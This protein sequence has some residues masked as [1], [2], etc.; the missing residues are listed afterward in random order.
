MKKFLLFVA[1]GIV[2]SSTAA[3]QQSVNWTEQDRNYL[4]TELTRSRDELIRE[5]K[6]LSEK[7]WNFKDSA[8]RW[9]INQIVEH[10]SIWEL[11]FQREISQAMAGGPQP[12]LQQN[13]KP[14]SAKLN[15]LKEEKPH[16][17]TEYTKPFTF[18]VPMGINKGENNMMWFLKL[19]NES[20][21]YLSTT[22]DDLRA[23][24]LKEGRGSIHQIYISTF[25]HTDRHLRQIRKLKAH[26]RYPK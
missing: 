14:D 1:T 5:T 9:S 21:N 26:L 20:L 12:A 11:L 25:G 22:K 6:G 2:L 8:N 24:Y 19:R 15:F 17:T 3:A 16:I 13:Q 23:Y 4:L 7:Q 10:L 18:S